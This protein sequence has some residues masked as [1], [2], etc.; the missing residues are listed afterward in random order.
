MAVLCLAVPR[1]GTRL[2]RSQLESWRERERAV[3]RASSPGEEG[4]RRNRALARSHTKADCNDDRYNV[5][6]NRYE[7]TSRRD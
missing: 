7:H 5:G 2:K 1:V 4:G 3:G 6:N